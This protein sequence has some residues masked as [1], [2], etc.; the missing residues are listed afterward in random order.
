[1]PLHNFFTGAHNVTREF[2]HYKAHLTISNNPNGARV[3]GGRSEQLDLVVVNRHMWRNMLMLLGS[4]KASTGESDTIRS[5]TITLKFDHIHTAGP[6]QS[7]SEQK[8]ILQVITDMWWSFPHFKIHGGDNQD[9]VVD[10]LRRVR[11]AR[12]QSF[13]AMIQSADEARG[14]AHGVLMGGRPQE[15]HVMFQEASIILSH[16]V[17]EF[18][19]A[20][21]SNPV[22]GLRIGRWS[23]ENTLLCTMGCLECLMAE[24]SSGRL[25]RPR[26]SWYGIMQTTDVAL[27]VL[28]GGLLRRDAAQ[29]HELLARIFQ[30][31]AYALR[32]L[33]RF[34]DA[35]ECL[36]KVYRLKPHDKDIKKELRSLK[37][38]RKTQTGDGAK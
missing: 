7:E 8:R 5:H 14:R 10:V 19:L 33:C 4:M 12:W 16:D 15:A 38:L 1:M 20:V 36:E 35:Q 9:A 17:H 37:E 23:F 26:N 13:D 6:E 18:L 32:K 2:K 11:S 30:C 27:R 29:S 25:I 21:S 22:E 28:K 34:K 3:R 24:C 31:R